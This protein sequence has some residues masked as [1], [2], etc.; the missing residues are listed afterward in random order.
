MIAECAVLQSHLWSLWSKMPFN[1]I[2]LPHFL[3]SA[4]ERKL[5]KVLW[6]LW[7]NTF[8]FQINTFIFFCINELPLSMWI[9]DYSFSDKKNITK[10]VP[11]SVYAHSF[12]PFSMVVLMTLKSHKTANYAAIFLTLLIQSQFYARQQ[13]I[14]IPVNIAKFVSHYFVF[15]SISGHIWQGH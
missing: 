11:L 4:S 5:S 12:N 9:E 7:V 8:C 2:S 14:N 15:N 1:Y 6:S 3:F 10:A 13:P